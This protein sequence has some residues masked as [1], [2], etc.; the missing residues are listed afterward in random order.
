MTMKEFLVA[1]STLEN[2]SSE[3]VE[4]ANAE[5]TKIENKNTKRR[6]TMT[7]TQQENADTLAIILNSLNYGDIITASWIAQNLGITTQK[8]SALLKIAVNSGKLIETEPQKGKNGKGKV[9]GYTLAENTDISSDSEGF[10]NVDTPI[11]I[12]SD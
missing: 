5:L 9:K 7:K 11:E 6:N 1:V 10:E 12:D 8:A 3:L 4:F 2:I